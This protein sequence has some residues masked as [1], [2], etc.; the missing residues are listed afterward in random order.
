MNYIP[1]LNDMAFVVKELLGLEPL[2]A[3]PGGEGAEAELFDAVLAE[4]A[5]LTQEVLVPLNPV[6][7]HEPARLDE[8]KVITPRGFKAAYEQFLAGGWN[9]LTAPAD[10]GGQGL[11]SI[12]AAPLEEMW[13]GANMA[14]TLG[15]LLTRGAVEAID[16]A[17]TAAQK[18]RYLPNLI[19][20]RWMGTMNLTE[21]Q[22]GSD[23]GA[24]RTHAVPAGDGS[25]RLT[26][27]KIFI[28][29]GDQD[30]T[31]NI[32]HLVLAR[33]PDAPAGVRGLSLFIVPKI[34][35]NDQ[36]N[37]AEP[38]QV[39]TVSLEHK[40]GIHGSPTCMLS[41]GDEGGAWG[42]LL[43]EPHR[44]LE[45]MFVMMNAAR[46]SVGVQG[47]AIGDRACQG[48][49]E[50]ARTRIQ[51]LPVGESQ[52]QPIVHHPD[53]LRMLAEMEARLQAGRTLAYY[54]GW[55]IDQAHLETDPQRKAR[56]QRRSDL[57]TPLV[58]GHCTE[59][60][61]WASNVALQVFGGMGFI[62][63]TGAAQHYRDARIT[64]I[65]EGTTGIQAN[66]LVG[67][68][69]WRDQGLAVRELLEEISATLKELQEEGKVGATVLQALAEVLKLTAQATERL[70]R[71][72]AT[73]PRWGLG[74]AVPYL[75]LLSYC[76]SAWWMARSARVAAWGRGGLPAEFY[77]Y[78]QNVV[79]FYA[80]HVLP[81]ALVLA[82]QIEA[83]GD[84]LESLRSSMAGDGTV[85]H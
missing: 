73:D 82:R 57:L 78:K 20:G 16:Y 13:H 74:V 79:S 63:E 76:V 34:L 35:L 6:G 5:R 71:Q 27:Q 8:G 12:F 52:L 80:A 49:L 61:V 41:Y 69:L 29:Y 83:P 1:P 68:K 36:G 64:T 15:P 67:R 75:H 44:G 7:D 48:A 18:V 53:V 2:A 58:K 21:P 33:L 24:L 66:D 46:F 72:G 31:E 4:S 84:L 40:L 55:M 60:G 62:E 47:L 50:Y 43:G 14:F 38:N 81:Q 11:P 3:L 85:I 39:R 70:L 28:T 22:A 37:L 17:G 59:L 26:G 54:A 51:G 56:A 19:T 32:I 65:Y 77:R 30:W 25:Y 42:E 9:G 45:L 10:F 23:L